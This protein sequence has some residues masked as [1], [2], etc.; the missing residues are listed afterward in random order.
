MKTE[1][2]SL[3]LAG[4]LCA[5]S[6]SVFAQGTIRFDWVDSY[7]GAG[8]PFQASF[9]LDASVVHPNSEPWPRSDPGNTYARTS[10]I[11]ITSPDH[12]FVNPLAIWPPG[13]EGT[14]F[15]SS[16]QLHLHLAGD[17]G[18]FSIGVYLNPYS[19]LGRTIIDEIETGHGV[20]YE[21]YGTWQ[22]T[23]I[24]EPSSF[25]LLGLGLLALCMKRAANR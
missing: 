5:A 1:F 7:N 10:G 11:T 15:D 20:T 6:S 2:K 16:G 12:T 21:A 22:Q 3:I 17:D 9:T 25:A 14:Y 8:G 13:S 18:D 23:V 4:L 24:P 19:N